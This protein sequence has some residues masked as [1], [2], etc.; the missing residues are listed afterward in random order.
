VVAISGAS[1]SNVVVCAND[2]LSK[3]ENIE[4]LINHFNMIIITGFT[5]AVVAFKFEN[6]PIITLD[7]WNV[8]PG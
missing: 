5:C 4:L 1:S 3:E 7:V 6:T 8:L 2:V